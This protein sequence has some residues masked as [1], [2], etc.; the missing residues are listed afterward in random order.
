MLTQ[1]NLGALTSGLEASWVCQPPHLQF[2]D[3]VNSYGR[4]APAK[5][6]RHHEQHK[7]NE[8]KDPGYRFRLAGNTS[9]AQCT[10]N[11]S[12]N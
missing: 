11:N 9:E 5:Y 4:P 10:R 3:T 12:D 8:E 1:A 6:E 7:K 2:T